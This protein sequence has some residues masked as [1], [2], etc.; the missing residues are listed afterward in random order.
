MGTEIVAFDGGTQAIY[1]AENQAQAE[2]AFRAFPSRSISL[3]SLSTLFHF[4]SPA[5]SGI[6]YPT[7]ARRS[8]EPTTCFKKWLLRIWPLSLSGSIHVNRNPSGKLKPCPPTPT[9]ETSSAEPITRSR[10]M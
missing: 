9:F 10:F 1:R 5:M 7:R 3:T 8:G 6:E 4:V 2:A